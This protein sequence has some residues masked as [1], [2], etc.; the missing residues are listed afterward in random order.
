MKLYRNYI[1]FVRCRCSKMRTKKKKEKIQSNI[2]FENKM[3][4]CA[5]DLQYA[6]IQSECLGEMN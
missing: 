2:S 1:K 5:C 4:K 6:P 3:R